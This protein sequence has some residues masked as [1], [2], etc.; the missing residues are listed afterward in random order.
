[1]SLSDHISGLAGALAVLQALEYR[2]R[3][4]RGQLVDLAQ[5]EV[6]AYLLGPAFLE[7]LV[8]DTE[9]QP[10]GNRDPFEGLEPNALYRCA[11]ERWVAVTARTD[12]EWL[13]LCAAIG[14]AELGADERLRHAL[15]R[16]EH[17]DHVDR[18]IGAW[19]A[20]RPAAGVEAALQSAGVPAGLVQ[21]ARD[22]AESDPQLR[23]R[24]WLTA[25]QHTSL[26]MQQIDRFPAQFGLSTLEPYRAS[27][28]LNEHTFKIYTE[29]LG[30]PEDEI[31]AALADGLFV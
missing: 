4:G 13:R 20:A 7:L 28:T 29:L 25:V 11:D 16:R 14:D 26:G 30:L 21:D 8:N 17:V 9:A 5:L 3:T 10:A 15:G 18:R 23:A 6:G 19:A 2:R 31:A 24:E 1:V 27:P 22:L 12:D